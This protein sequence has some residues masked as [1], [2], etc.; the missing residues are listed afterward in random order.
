MS[1]LVVFQ[2]A[3]PGGLELDN[4]K[5]RAVVWV[6]SEALLALTILTNFM[7]RELRAV[8]LRRSLLTPLLR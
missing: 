8:S 7:A 2:H 4:I 5:Y 1:E 3:F 6:I